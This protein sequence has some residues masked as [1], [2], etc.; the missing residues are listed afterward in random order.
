[1]KGINILGLSRCLYQNWV[2]VSPDLNDLYQSD[3]I[4]YIEQIE[5]IYFFIEFS[6]AWIHKLT[7]ELGFTEKQ[8][9]F[10]Y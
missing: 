2:K 5:Q 8:I 9:P 4:C 10:L 3:H 1:M 7:P 6:I